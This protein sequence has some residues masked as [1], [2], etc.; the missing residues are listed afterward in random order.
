MSLFKNEQFNKFLPIYMIVLSLVL[1]LGSSYA[2]LK[3][4]YTGTNSYTINVGLLQVD[5]FGTTNKLTLNNM[6][7][8]SDEDGLTQNNALEFT[9]KNTGQLI[10]SYDVYID[11]TSNNPSFKS[12]IRYAVNKDDLGYGEVQSLTDNMLYIDKSKILD[13]NGEANYK[14]KIWLDENATSTYMNKVFTAKV[15]IVSNQTVTIQLDATGGV[16]SSNTKVIAANSTTY[17]ELPEPT[18]TGFEF[19]GWWTSEDNAGTEVMESTTF[20][21]GTSVETLYAHWKSVTGGYLVTF[22][23]QGGIG[24]TD[25]VRVEFGE[26][27]P[28][29]EKPIKE[30]N[31]SF[32]G[33]FSEINGTGIKYYDENMVSVKNY[34][35]NE[36]LTLYASWGNPLCQLN[37][38]E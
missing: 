15:V 11:E 8:M 20:T 5:F 22:D 37:P 1:L 3:S 38:F 24:G 10:A 32:C 13:V 29:A 34:D 25:S 27:M 35:I 33:Y 28:L 16:L 18:R 36:D 26:S 31:V 17:G 9:V 4:S 19:A 21:Y 2:L 6:V 14:V 12:V 23:K 30:S 7:P